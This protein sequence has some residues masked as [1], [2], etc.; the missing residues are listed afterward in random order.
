MFQGHRHREAAM[1]D[2]GTKVYFEVITWRKGFNPGLDLEYD[3]GDLDREQFLEEPDA[4]RAAK[5]YFIGGG[6]VRLHRVERT[7]LPF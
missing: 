2:Y 7:E 6:G 1:S 4:I 3:H 5:D